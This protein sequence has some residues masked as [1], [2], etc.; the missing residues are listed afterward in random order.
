LKLHQPTAEGHEIALIDCGLM[1][2]IGQED[3]DKMIS[4]VI[5]L[6][7]KDYA[8]LVD[9]FMALGI[10][11]PDSER[12]T[13]I[14]LMDKALS[15][16]VK[17]GGAKSY[18]AELKRMYGMEES[19]MSSQ[20]GGFQAMTQDALTVLND[21][22][23]SIP[24]YFAILGRA[25]VTL[26]GIALTG[27]PGYGLIMEAYPF[28]A[29][30]LLR[31]DRPEIQTALQEVLYSGDAA[32]SANGALKLNR[33]LVLLNNAAGSVGKQDGGAF[34][35]LD[36]VPEDGMTLETGLKYI[37]S[38]NADSLRTLLEPEVETIADVLSR[39]IIRKGLNEAI[40]SLT[41]PRP[42][43]IP[44]LGNI[45]PS[46]PNPKIDE[47]PLPILLPAKSGNPSDPPSIGVLNLRDF[48]DF[49]APKLDRNEEIYAIGLGDAAAEFFG[50]DVAAFVR[51]ESILSVNTAQM[52]LQAARQQAGSGNALL[53]SDGAQQVMRGMS[54]LLDSRSGTAVKTDL[55][56]FFEASDKL[57]STE[58]ERLD[59]ILAQIIN[60]TVARA[61][62]RLREVPRLF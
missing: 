6:A 48:I 32:G 2:R 58:S 61:T 24:P 4:A 36:T 28:I 60:R 57:D 7:N 25:I 17:G 56:S 9:D 21:V 12:A 23:F 1:A 29:R 50:E 5:H 45:L 13:I 39:Q 31:D 14:P 37:M 19:N 46:L 59:D 20:V 8:S 62:E 33:L 10:L 11:P 40:V 18:E 51:G 27:D 42:P 47:I 34:V 30:Q 26:E 22:P 41:P 16:Y 54:S 53:S 15:P 3:R 44:F 38:D 49:V 55:A 35:D 43:S 52:V